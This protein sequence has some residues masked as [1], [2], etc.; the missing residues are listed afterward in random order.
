MRIFLRPTIYVGFFESSFDTQFFN[1]ISIVNHFIALCNQWF[2]YLVLG[3]MCSMFN[4]LHRDL[5]FLY[6]LSVLYLFYD[7]W[8]RT[9][10]IFRRTF[11]SVHL[12]PRSTEKAQ[13]TY[14][15]MNRSYWWR[16]IDES[17]LNNRISLNKTLLILMHNKKMWMQRT[18]HSHFLHFFMAIDIF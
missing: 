18:W 5:K 1:Q 3:R 8:G 15:A 16:S 10:I 7:H 6:A 12:Q 17:E 13:N 11:I 2:F 14:Q 4:H 9:A